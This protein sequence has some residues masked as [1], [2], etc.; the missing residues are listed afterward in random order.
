MMRVALLSLSLILLVFVSQTYA[1]CE[2]DECVSICRCGNNNSGS[3]CIACCSA[4][5]TTDSANGMYI[6]VLALLIPMIM[7]FIKLFK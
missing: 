3:D 1:S 4:Y 2:C 6:G 5:E 7:A